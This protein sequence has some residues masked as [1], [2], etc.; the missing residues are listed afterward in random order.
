M[1]ISIDELR[2]L[3]T[4]GLD[5]LEMMLGEVVDLR[6]IDYWDTNPPDRYDPYALTHEIGLGDLAEDMDE[7]RETLAEGDQS[8]TAWHVIPLCAV[9]RAIAETAERNIDE[10]SAPEHDTIQ[11]SGSTMLPAPEVDH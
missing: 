1:K 10:D 7:L 9:L 11:Q 5:S 3:A 2:L 4:R 6:V 8:T